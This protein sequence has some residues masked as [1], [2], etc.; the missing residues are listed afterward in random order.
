MQQS[1][2][3]QSKSLKENRMLEIILSAMQMSLLF[4][5]FMKITFS[6]QIRHP[7]YTILNY[8]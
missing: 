5:T 6:E 8:H 7:M 1:Y 2:T 4:K 3:I